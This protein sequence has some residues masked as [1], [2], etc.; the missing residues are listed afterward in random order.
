MVQS[1]KAWRI[2]TVYHGVCLNAGLI[3]M[4]IILCFY[5]EKECNE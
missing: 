5:H 1:P 3:L 2:Q 4:K